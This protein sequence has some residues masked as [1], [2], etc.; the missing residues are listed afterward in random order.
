M[1]EPYL[2]VWTAKNIVMNDKP[3]GLAMQVNWF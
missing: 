1:H 2:F 3:L